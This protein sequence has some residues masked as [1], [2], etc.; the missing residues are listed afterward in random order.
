[1]IHDI[2]FPPSLRVPV[3]AYSE[4]FPYRFS[5]TWEDGF[6]FYFRGQ[7]VSTDEEEFRAMS[8]QQ[9]TKAVLRRNFIPK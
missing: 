3:P 2:L 7:L 8:S 4:E 9:M 5:L 1:M 6:A